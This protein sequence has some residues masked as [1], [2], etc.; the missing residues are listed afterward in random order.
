[1]DRDI[2][3]ISNGRLKRKDNTLYFVSEKDIST[4]VP[5]EQTG[6][7]H[8]FGQIDFNT[9]LLHLLTKHD[10][11]LHVYNYYGYYDGT[12]YPRNPRVSGYAVV[13][14][15]AHVL[16]LSKRI[17]LA[18]LFLDGATFHMLR[19]LRKYNEVTT[20]YQEQI[21]SYLPF[22]D[23]AK[24]INELMGIEGKCRKTYYDAFEVMMK[25][26]WLWEGRTKQS[27]QDP[28]NALISFG[29]SMMYTAVVSELYKT[30][31]DPSISFLHEP[32]SKRFSLSLD[33]SEIFKPL[34]VDSIIFNL[35]NNH[36]ITDTHFEH[37]TGMTYLNDEGRKRFITAFDEKMKTTIKHRTLKRNVS[38]RYLIRLEAY[39][40]IKHI[41]GD[42]KYKPLKAWW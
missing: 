7:I 6:S 40:L 31:L 41:I 13:Q 20:T 29:N 32:S 1:M 5:I 25:N 38:Y 35:I 39:K 37:Q 23:R 4:P 9:S 12:Y 24:N 26:G 33:I 18:R 3:M 14:Q 34:I 42:A 17:E 28:I 8:L 21:R 27:P 11:V 19:N 16:N 10:V 2:F 15:A 30:M 36:R 22:M